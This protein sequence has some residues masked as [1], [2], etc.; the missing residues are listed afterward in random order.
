MDKQRKVL[1]F[2]RCFWF[3][4]VPS[5]TEP[6]ICPQLTASSVTPEDTY[7]EKWRLRGRNTVPLGKVKAIGVAEIDPGPWLFPSQV[8][9]IKERGFPQKGDSAPS[10]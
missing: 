1:I 2:Q 6:P 3:Q 7:R 4:A 9:L 5:A 10:P 8:E